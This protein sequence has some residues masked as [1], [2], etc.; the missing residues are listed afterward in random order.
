MHTQEE[1]AW[2]SAPAKGKRVL[3]ER[4]YSRGMKDVPGIKNRAE[5]FTEQSF[6]IRRHMKADNEG[7]RRNAE[8]YRK[9][10]I[11]T[12]HNSG[13]APT[14]NLKLQGRTTLD[15]LAE[16][17]IKFLKALCEC[18]STCMNGKRDIFVK[19]SN[20]FLLSGQYACLLCARPH[21]TVTTSAAG[22]QVHAL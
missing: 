3:L 11:F 21:T 22:V 12:K 1:P 9:C 10:K 18:S 20:T 15:L 14:G 13:R 19:R 4:C 6:L 5:L 7:T 8:L 17:Q 16:A 2:S